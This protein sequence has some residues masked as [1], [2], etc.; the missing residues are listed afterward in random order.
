[1]DLFSSLNVSLISLGNIGIGLGKLNAASVLAL[2]VYVKLFLSFMMIAGRL[3]L[4]TAFVFF[5]KAYWR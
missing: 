5:S 4:W 2:P 1:M 3:E